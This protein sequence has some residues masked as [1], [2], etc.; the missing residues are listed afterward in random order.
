MRI[1]EEPSLEYTID[2]VQKYLDGRIDIKAFWKPFPDILR[3]YFEYPEDPSHRLAYFWRRN[4]FNVRS[5]VQVG[6]AEMEPGYREYLT[7]WLGA[8]QKPE[9]E[10]QEIVK[11]KGWALDDI[12][13][14]WDK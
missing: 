12:D 7:L 10:W 8:L 2:H 6:H 1:S 5:I 9:E 14:D 3:L 11:R 13:P 4:S